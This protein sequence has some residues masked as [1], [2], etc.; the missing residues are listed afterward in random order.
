MINFYKEV[1]L[2]EE[3]LSEPVCDILERVRHHLSVHHLN[4][5]ENIMWLPCH[6]ID[7]HA[8]G[9]LNAH[10]DSVRFSGDI[11]AGISLLSGSIMR[12]YE[13][14]RD[15]VSEGK[16][17]ENACAVDIGSTTDASG[18]RPY[19]DLYLPP[20]S[21]YVLSGTARYRYTHE[22]L[23]AGSSFRGELPVCRSRRMSII[24]RDAKME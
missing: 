19:V 23:P 22:L 11:V 14:T 17:T 13:E 21:L 12:L 15:D 2:S 20:Q 18:H 5:T 3:L 9:D 1:E 10:V 6:A 4:K 7:L 24:F 16:E 8:T